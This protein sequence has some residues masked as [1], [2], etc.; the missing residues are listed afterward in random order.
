MLRIGTGTPPESGP[1]I[2]KRFSD[3][4][5]QLVKN[6]PIL[7]EFFFRFAGKVSLALGGAEEQPVAKTL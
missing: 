3:I 7:D 5:G 2:T 6:R 4:Q 1:L